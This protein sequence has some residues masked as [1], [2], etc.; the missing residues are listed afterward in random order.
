[1]LDQTTASFIIVINLASALIAC[2]VI[3]MTQKKSPVTEELPGSFISALLLTN[4]P[5][6]ARIALHVVRKRLIEVFAS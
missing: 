4:Q 3:I 5:S 6:K 2:G 1:M